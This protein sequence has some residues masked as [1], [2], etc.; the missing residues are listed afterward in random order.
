VFDE[1]DR[2]SDQG[3]RD[4]MA[5]TIKHFSDYP[6]NITIVIVGVG[7]SI[8]ELFGAHP[9]I[10][11]CCQHIPMPR[12]SKD[13]LKEILDERYPKIGITA[14]IQVEE[15]LLDLAQGL[16]GYVHLA[17]REAALSAIRRK[18]RIIE[19]YDYTVSISESLR[20]AHESIVAAYNKAI[21]SAKENMYAEV[22]LACAL[23][24]TDERGK[25]S[26]SD[27]RDALSK[28]LNKPVQISNFARHLG[29][30]CDPSRGPVLRKTGKPKGFQYQFIDA[31][32]HPYVV[33]AGRKS[34]L[35]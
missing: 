27:V 29:A 3:T 15:K 21:Y 16:P 14:N 2:I 9:S 13:E 6:Q 20:R 35:I 10:Q 19:D 23:T 28:L 18:S 8:E 12:M 22:L 7:F 11:R 30:F 31:P 1:F 26:A 24:K 25:F 34:G 17:G 4:A 32:L 5:D 33:M